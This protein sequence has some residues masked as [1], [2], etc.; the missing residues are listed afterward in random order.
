MSVDWVLTIGTKLA[1]SSSFF[2][3][4][5]M[6]VWK[7]H[8]GKIARD[9]IVGIRIGLVKVILFEIQFMRYKIQQKMTAAADGGGGD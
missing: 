4:S 1:A 3:I 9:R 5:I 6:V 7:L 2:L 8:T